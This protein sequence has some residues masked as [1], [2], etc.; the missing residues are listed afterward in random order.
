MMEQTKYRFL[1]RRLRR[2]IAQTVRGKAVPRRAEK[3]KTAALTACK[4]YGTIV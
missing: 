3:I 4:A 1:L 2:E